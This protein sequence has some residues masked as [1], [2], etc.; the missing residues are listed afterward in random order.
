M[1]DG[2]VVVG[3]FE[4]VGLPFVEF[5]TT[6]DVLEVDP[7]VDAAV[8]PSLPVPE[9]EGVDEPSSSRDTIILPPVQ[10]TDGQRPLSFT[11]SR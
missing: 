6:V 2:A 4:V 7:D 10:L 11:T 8:G 1:H 9:A 3:H 5:C